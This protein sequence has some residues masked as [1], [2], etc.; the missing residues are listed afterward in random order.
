MKI[1][2]P[3]IIFLLSSEDFGAFDRLYL[4]DLL[5]SNNTVLFVDPSN[6]L[7]EGFSYNYNLT[8]IKEFKRD[9]RVH[10]KHN[11]ATLLK[12]ERK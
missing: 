11:K 7:Y 4:E 3:Q 1:I 9:P 12:V 5:N 2:I 6:G 10:M 8:T